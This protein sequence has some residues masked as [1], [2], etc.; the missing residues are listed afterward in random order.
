MITL[1]I[2]NCIFIV[3]SSENNHNTQSFFSPL[4]EKNQSHSIEHF[5]KTTLNLNYETPENIETL[6][7]IKNN[8][9]QRIKDVVSFFKKKE[10]HLRAAHQQQAQA[11]DTS[12]K[13]KNLVNCQTKK[14]KQKAIEDIK[15][16]CPDFTFTENN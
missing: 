12:D 11:L 15:T 10:E 9:D 6:S 13:I 4:V 5:L 16:N 7:I 3:F 2:N 8:Y 1:L 14:L